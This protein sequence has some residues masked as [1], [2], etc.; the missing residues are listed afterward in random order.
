M[1]SD[2]SDREE[3]GMRDL[4]RDNAE[5]S[6]NRSTERGA[7]SPNFGS[8]R[9]DYGQLAYGG[10][11]DEKGMESL[12]TRAGDQQRSFRSKGSGRSGRGGETRRWEI[13]LMLLG[14]VG[15]GSALIYF[16]VPEWQRGRRAPARGELT[17]KKCGDVMTRDPACCLPA[18]TAERAAQL[19][20]SEDVGPVP[21]VSDHQTKRL[22]GIVTDRDLALKVVAEARDARVTRV[23]DVMTRGVVACRAEDAVQEALDAMAEHQVRRIPVVDTDDRIVG[24]IA[25]ADVATR[26]GEPERMAEVVEEIS[27][28]S[29]AGI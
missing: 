4:G 21:V 5:R 16:L 12:S 28:S 18:D 24:I 6:G 14:G 17:M 8:A 25:Q 11:L 22:V 27:R 13:G 19:M 7:D 26:T 3:S 2:F 1:S 9:S 23:E 29:A 15:I 10:S 20:K